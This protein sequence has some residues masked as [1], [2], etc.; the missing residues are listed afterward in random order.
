M[1]IAGLMA[2][3]IYSLNNQNKTQTVETQEDM[4]RVF[5]CVLSTD[6][7]MCAVFLCPCQCRFLYWRSVVSWKWR[8]LVHSDFYRMILAKFIAKIC[9]G[10][11]HVCGRWHLS[12]SHWANKVV[13]SQTTG[14]AVKSLLL[15]TVKDM[16]ACVECLWHPTQQMVGL[17]H[18]NH[19]WLRWSHQNGYGC[20]LFSRFPERLQVR[21]VH[22]TWL[23]D[24][25]E[26]GHTFV[27]GEWRR[28]GLGLLQF[29]QGLRGNYNNQAKLQC[30]NLKHVLFALTALAV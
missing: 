24:R 22:T 13:V 27:K 4:E 9:C 14:Q 2:N 28:K 20:C 26:A 29:L 8:S 21:G 17:L 11:Y 15:P 30:D 10:I 5:Y 7:Y 18:N 23:T 12:T 3:W 25:E 6:P 19:P 16:Q 1:P